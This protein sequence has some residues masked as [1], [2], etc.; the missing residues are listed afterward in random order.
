M[1]M[2]A[3]NPDEMGRLER[4]DGQVFVT[5]IRKLPHPPSTVWRALTEPDHLAAWFPTTIE[6]AA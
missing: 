6:G 3:S 1:G 2:S 4:R 5:F